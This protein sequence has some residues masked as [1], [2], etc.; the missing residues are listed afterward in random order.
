MKKILLNIRNTFYFLKK[1]KKYR[2]FVKTFRENKSFMNYEI[3]I[4]EH[5]L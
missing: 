2:K 3:N 4:F 1:L 5:V